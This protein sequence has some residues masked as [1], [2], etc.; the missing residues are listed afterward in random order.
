MRKVGKMLFAALTI[1]NIGV[2]TS[3]AEELP[4]VNV[5][6]SIDFSET[7]QP[8]E[9]PV[10]EEKQADNHNYIG[11]FKLTSY[12]GCRRCNG[13]WTGYPSKIGE[14]LTVNRTVAVDPAVIPLGTWIEIEVPGKGWETFRAEDTGSGVK[15]NHIDVYI[16]E[17]HSNVYNPYYN[18]DGQH[19]AKVR[20][21]R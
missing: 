1:M 3:L 2:I 18:T 15:G 7:I 21:V 10:I 11:D 19:T 14:P 20:Y 16:G 13:K 4:E 12:C 9:E 5:E 6:T 17:G 8:E